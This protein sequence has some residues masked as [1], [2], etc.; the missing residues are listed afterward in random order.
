MLSQHGLSYFKDS[1]KC[2]QEMQLFENKVMSCMCHIYRA[3]IW[4][5]LWCH[6]WMN[7][8][9]FWQQFLHVKVVDEISEEI[10]STKPY[11]AFEKNNNTTIMRRHSTP[12][13]DSETAGDANREKLSKQNW[14]HGPR[15]VTCKHWYSVTCK[16]VANVC[17]CSTFLQEDLCPNTSEPN[18]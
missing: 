7:I 14:I 10:S 6:V 9:G 12:A 17:I 16:S 18:M 1:C 2:I 8:F 15:N 3:C 5:R 13:P 4:L 11:Q